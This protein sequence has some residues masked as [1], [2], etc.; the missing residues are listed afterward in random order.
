MLVEKQITIGEVVTLKL[1][2]GEELIARY[3]GETP[4]AV[5][6]DKP[7]ALVAG[8]KSLGMIPYIFLANATTVLINK[9]AIVVGP[10]QSKKD[11]AA[12]YL[13]GTTGI[14]LS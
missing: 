10:M 3:D 8:G 12:Q 9:T 14:A 1:V 7:L 2:S 6:L 4:D 5:R 11:A 13:E